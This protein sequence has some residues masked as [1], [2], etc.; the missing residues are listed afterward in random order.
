MKS[1]RQRFEE[2]TEKSGDCVL[3]A[4]ATDRNG[5]GV[6]R[7]PKGSAMRAHRFAYM[8]YVGPLPS[9]MLVCHRCDVRNCVNPNHL[10]LGTA[11]DNTRD[12]MEKER[13]RHR[14]HKGESNGASKLTRDQAFYIKRS[15]ESGVSLANRFNVSRSTISAVRT[16]QNWAWL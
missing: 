12:M 7:G 2:K 5:Y 10:F 8:M 14:S 9:E 13:G 6:F 15:E 3:W 16:G 1:T 4:G 11:A